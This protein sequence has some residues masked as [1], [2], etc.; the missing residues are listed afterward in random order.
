M[1]ACEQRLPEA[2]I[3][4]QGARVH[5]LRALDI[6]IPR[7]RLIACCGVSG[8]GKSSLA[9]GVLHAEGQRRL[10]EALSPRLRGRVEGLPRPEVDL[11]TG[12]PPTI[13]VSAQ[14]GPAR[15]RSTLA[16][17]TELHELF[18]ALW[19]HRGVARCPDCGRDLPTHTADAATSALLALAEGTRLTVL[20]PV[21]RGRAGG[22]AEIF[23]EMQRLGFAR[24]RLDGRLIRLEDRPAVDARAAHDLDVVVDRV[25]VGPERED[26][27]LEAV[28]LAWGAGKGRMIALAQVEGAEAEE[29]LFFADHPAC[30]LG[31]V[32]LAPATPALFS[33]NTA[34]GAC[35]RCEG[36]GRAPE[37]ADCPDCG[38]SRLSETA[39]I[40]RVGGRSLPELLASPVTEALGWLE[41]VPADA[42]TGPLLAEARRRLGRL[43]ALGLGYLA[44][45]RGSDTLSAGEARRVHLAS[46]ASGDLSGVL[47]VI[48]EPTAGLGPAES[49]AVRAVIEELVRAGNTALVVTHDPALLLAAELVL[50]LGPGAGAEGGRLLYQGPPGGLQGADTPTGRALSGRLEAPARRG[51][52][53]RGALEIVGAR[54][55]GLGGPGGRLDAR[56]PLGCL[57]VVSGPSGSGK[58]ALIEGTLGRALAARLHGAGS[59]PLPHD[60]IRGAEGLRRLVRLSQA[61]LG[62]SSRSCTA[63][64]AG[65]WGPIRRLLAETREAR[66][67]GY[68][69]ETFSFNRAGGRCA[70][71]EGTGVRAIRLH[72][73]PELEA[74]CERCEGRRFGP[75]ALAV[76]Y[77]GLDAAGLLGLTVAEARRVFMAQP[78]IEP[79]LRTLER[80]GLGYLRLGQPADT[81]SGGEAE[82]ARLARELGVPSDLPG[83]LYLLDA[84]SL[85]L[86]PLDVLRLVDLLQE[87]VDQGASAIAVD[88][89]PI[90]LAAA[91]HRLVLGPGAGPEGGRV[92]AQA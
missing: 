91:D 26:R 21:L 86:H 23:D 81:L 28:Q 64:V 39:R 19:A 92:V 69:P 70:A 42:A 84:P 87:L 75:G 52:A 82:R 58:T 61:P 90:L 5:N 34:E 4:V 73:L 33:F 2:M 31:H 6:D 41:G 49:A 14:A 1:G 38:G 56:L 53:G 71:C 57:S 74:P 30:P 55:L 7:G 24:A 85:G 78:A 63:T 43:R 79:R 66:V 9:F 17:R 67:R 46:Q 11:I 88:N 44:L 68:G 8:S 59:P 3:R 50:E 20:A 76:R 60:A 18:R 72:L 37:G 35:A 25:R 29:E 89:D 48:D 45:G 32:S 62:R 80:A 40:Y 36:T 10:L 47:Y 13:G 65:I 15:A 22:L 27:V 54:G 16:T 77:R 83:T 12:L 51:R